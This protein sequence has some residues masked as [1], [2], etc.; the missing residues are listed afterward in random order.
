MLLLTELSGEEPAEGNSSSQRSNSGLTT[1]TAVFAID[2]DV[3][4]AAREM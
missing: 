3:V 4:R 2:R 1:I